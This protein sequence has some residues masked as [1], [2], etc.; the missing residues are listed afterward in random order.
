MKTDR[1]DDALSSFADGLK[2]IVGGDVSLMH[3]R[4]YVRVVVGSA[5][6]C[7]VDTLSGEILKPDTWN[8]PRRT[9]RSRGSIYDAQ[10][11]LGQCCRN[12]LRYHDA[13]GESQ[14]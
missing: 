1:F 6:Y 5:A 3:G 10:N 12:S 13:Y 2:N 4:R 7:F 9:K 14:S 11:G 8:G